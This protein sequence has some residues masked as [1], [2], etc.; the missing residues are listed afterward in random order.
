M[1]VNGHLINQTLHSEKG[2][3]EDTVKKYIR[4]IKKNARK[5]W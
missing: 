5:K 3:N 2:E 4:N 1:N